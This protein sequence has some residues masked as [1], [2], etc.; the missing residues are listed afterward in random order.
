M[1]VEIERKFL[2]RNDDWRSAVRDTQTMRQGYLNN[3]TRCSIRV[4]TNGARAWLNIKSVT[5]GAQRQEF[6]YE[7]PLDDGNVLLDTLAHRPFIE[8]HRHL[9]DVGRHVW[10]IDEFLGDN[11]GLIVAEIELHEPEEAFELPSW[12]GQ[13]VTEDVR[14]YNTNLCRHPFTTWTGDDKPV[15]QEFVAR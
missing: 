3:E 1:A 10:E 14:Y 5:I 13:E 15:S 4:R 2:I 8:K 7:I 11:A 12:L 6:E 9:V